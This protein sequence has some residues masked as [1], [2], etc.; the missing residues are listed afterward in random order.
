MTATPPG[1]LFTLG[2][3][4]G[5]PELLT[6]KA[7]RIL[8]TA[9]VVAYFAKAGQRG[10]ARTIAEGRIG[11][12][13]E[14]LRFDYPVTVEIPHTDG[15]YVD[16]MAG[17]Y[18]AAAEAIAARLGQGL[19][20]ALLCEGD[21]FFYGSSM[22]LFDRLRDR[23]PMEIVPGV[24]G[25]SGCWAQAKLPMTHG[26]DVLAVVPGTMTAAALADAL[27]GADAA[28]VMKLGRNLAKVRAVLA[29]LGRAERAVYVERGTMPTARILPLAEVADGAAPYFSMILVPGRQG[30]R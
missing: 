6:L 18:H 22:Y 29:A 21:P 13:A 25:M 28:V 11:P 30:P 23:F 27:R 15:R 9:P 24:L 2:M 3:G 5:D 10:H 16:A 26:D 14:E 20:V 17:C 19:D 7:A 1:T 4:P 8:G 12:A